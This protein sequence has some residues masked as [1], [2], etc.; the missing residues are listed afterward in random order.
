MA[1]AS[2]ELMRG[3]LQLKTQF[4]M[5]R[6]TCRICGFATHTA[7]SPCRSFLVSSAKSFGDRTTH[8]GHVM[9]VSGGAE[10]DYRR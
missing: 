10:I 2:R 6:N 8:E 9:H 5:S 3:W 7:C 4:A 1:T